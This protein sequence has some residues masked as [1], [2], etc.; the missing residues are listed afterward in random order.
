MFRGQT[1][2]DDRV[3]LN[4]RGGG[5][6]AFTIRGDE[7]WSRPD[8]RVLA[9]DSEVA[10]ALGDGLAALGIEASD[11]RR[12]L[13]TEATVAAPANGGLFVPVENSPQDIRLSLY[14]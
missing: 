14:Q 12:G 3:F 1:I 10:Y 11:R 2:V 6:T 8:A 7:M 5:V 13:D 4:L 9:V